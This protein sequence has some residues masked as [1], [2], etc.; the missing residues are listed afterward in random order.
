MQYES[1][2][3]GALSVFGTPVALIPWPDTVGM[4]PGATATFFSGTVIES[5]DVPD[6]DGFL[7]RELADELSSATGGSWH[8]ARGA[9]QGVVRLALDEAA[10]PRSYTLDVRDGGIAITGG[11]LEGLRYGVQTLRQM[12]RQCGGVLP[13]VRIKDAPQYAVRGYYLDVTRGR[14]PTLDWLKRW[15]CEL[16]LCK[17]NQLHLYI[18][19]S[20]AFQGLSEAWRG[21]DPLTAEQIMAF[22]AFCA[23]RGIELVPSVSTF[24]HLYAVLRTQGLRHLGEFP[25]DAD[26]P[27]SFI[28]RQEHHTL[29]ILLD[30]SFKLSTS[31]IDQYLPLFRSRKFNIGADETFDLGRGRSHGEAERIG[32]GRM[33]A[34][35]VNRLCAYLAD[36][37]REPMLWGDIVLEHPQALADLDGGAT[38]LNWQ[39]EP[40]V[41][42]DKVRVLAD[43]GARQYVCPAVQGWNRT[44]PRLHD[45]WRNIDGL[46][47]HGIRYGAEGFLLTDWG[48]YG[49]VNDPRLSLPAMMYG[50]E[51]SWRGERA[52]FD[53]DQPARWLAD[54]RR[55]DRRRDGGMGR[56]QPDGRRSHGTTRYACWNSTRATAH[57]IGMCWRPSRS[58]ATPDEQSWFRLGR[59]RGRSERLFLG[60]HGRGWAP[61]RAMPRALPLV[62]RALAKAR[63]RAA[64]RRE[65]GVLALAARGQ[66]LFDACGWWLAVDAGVLERTAGIPDMGS[67]AEL[68]QDLE[69]WFEEYRGSWR[70]ISRESELDRIGSVVWRLAD[71]LRRIGAGSGDGA[72]EAA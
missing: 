18:E 38:L 57:S 27:F 24:G 47:A 68:A 54:F 50:A 9:W 30:E 32:V 61:C 23:E 2:S 41:T 67:P 46:S 65:A 7:A 69:Y 26:R 43:A 28:E 53:E 56:T 58:W 48:D 20:F 62:Q 11:D 25:E 64:D 8:A 70:E 60:S 3:P 15:A 63:V 17:Y 44:L 35:Y 21:L 45:A 72:P 36:R 33:Y 59:D 31:M 4:V 34:R 22:D 14:V 40:D 55:H 29:N 10:A 6:A 19:H 66:D 1:A 37:G 42:D 49:H 12:L 51:C 52:G 71:M 16:E 5:G 13:I 39:Y